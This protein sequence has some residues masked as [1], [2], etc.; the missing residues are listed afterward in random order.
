[1]KREDIIQSFLDKKEVPYSLEALKV[2]FELQEESLK[3]RVYVFLQEDSLEEGDYSEDF[4]VF[5]SKHSQINSKIEQEL[6]KVAVDFPLLWDELIIKHQLEKEVKGTYNVLSRT[7]NLPYEINFL[8]QDHPILQGLRHLDLET[9]IEFNAFLKQGSI[10]LYESQ[11]D[12]TP[13]EKNYQEVK[14]REAKETSKLHEHAPLLKKALGLAT[15]LGMALALS[16]CGQPP[17]DDTG[18]GFGNTPPPI[19]NSPDCLL[20]RATFYDRL[21]QL[22]VG[23]T[24]EQVDAVLDPE[25]RLRKGTFKYSTSY[26]IEGFDYSIPGVVTCE[27]VQIHYDAQ[28]KFR[29]FTVRTYPL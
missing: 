13:F 1:M 11:L 17:V 15:T 25:Y 29:L 22:R 7:H 5:L 26:E 10:Y 3:D 8:N 18:G 20:R 21:D 28:W 2:A 19:N 23:M 16:A 4:L 12:L 14:T 27:A 9:E 24:E 6:V